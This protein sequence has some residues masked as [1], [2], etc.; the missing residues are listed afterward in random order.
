MDSEK[1]NQLW[2]NCLSSYNIQILTKTN[3]FRISYM[4]FHKILD[5]YKVN[6]VVVWKIIIILNSYKYILEKYK[7]L[8]VLRNQQLVKQFHQLDKD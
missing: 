3:S 8:L 1:K 5:I 2:G 7:I 6:V 4:F